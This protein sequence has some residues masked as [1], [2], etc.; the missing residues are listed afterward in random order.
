MFKVNSN[1]GRKSIYLLKIIC[2]GS[3]YK[4]HVDSISS[5]HVTAYGPGLTHGVSGD[6][7]QFTIST[8]GAGAGGLSLAVEGPSKANVNDFVFISKRCF[9]FGIYCLF[10]SPTTITRTVPSESPTCPQ[11]LA[12][13]R[14]P[15]VSATNTSTVHH[16]SPRSPARVESVTRFRSDLARKFYFLAPLPMMICAR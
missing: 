4:F 12:N 9:L 1:F 15:C 11:L 2:S 5:G 13:T 7:T 8:K 16:S 14:S 3:P 6:P 10:R